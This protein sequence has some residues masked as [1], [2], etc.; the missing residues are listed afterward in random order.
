M[1]KQI[2]IVE[3]ERVSAEVIKMSLQRLGYAA[4]GMAVSGE[5]A[6]KKAEEILPDLALMD[7]VLKGE[8]D[9]IEAA[10]IISS[11]LDIPVVYLTAHADN[12][13]L[14]RAK[15]TEPFGYILK[16]FDDKELQTNIE[17]ALYKHK[18]GNMLKESE[19][20]YRS[21]VENSHDAIYIIAQDAFQYANPG[22]E[23][24][25]GWKREELC[26]KK[27]NFRNIIHPDDIKKIKERK[28]GEKRGTEVLPGR[29]FRIISKDGTER[30][31]EATRA[32]IGKKGEAK[33]VGI[34]RD[35][36]G[37]KK[38]E[39]ELK[40]SFEKLQK[41]FEGT[42]NALVSALE[43]RDPYAA[44]H[45]KRVTKL[46]CAIAREMDLSKDQIDGLRLAGPVHDVGKLRIPADI[47]TKPYRLSQFE[48]VIVKMHPQMGYEIL[49]EV[50][51]PYPVAQIVLQHHE[52]TDGSGYPEGLKGEKTLLEARIMGVA[53]VVEAMSSYRSYRPAL[54]TCL[55]LKEITKDKGILYDAVVVDACLKLFYEKKFKF[56]LY[57]KSD[58]PS[59]EN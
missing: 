52:R 57:L 54:G 40:E 41:S 28:K 18:M 21:V 22:F 3:D 53:D 50:E 34:L 32:K 35:I 42:I 33:E 46:A 37:R 39:G 43:T 38:A 4:A 29:E 19:E 5:E 13:T 31:V 25:T 44:N 27:L 9:G 10:S 24:L 49:K 7:I 17:M 56:E 11:R 36:T 14:A 1:K 8:M 2:L 12:K 47:L 58:I 23:K 15:I 48:F 51:F 20:R 30:I 59:K 16:P 26:N 45:Q 55:A 6:V